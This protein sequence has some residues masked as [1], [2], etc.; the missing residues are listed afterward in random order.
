[1]SEDLPPPPPPPEPIAAPVTPSSSPP[2][3]Q[4]GGDSPAYGSGSV[5]ATDDKLYCTLA[6][7]FSIIIWLWKKD[8]SPAVNVHGRVA[9][10]FHLTVFA[11]CLALYVIA[12]IPLVGCLTV[13]A[14]PIVGLGGLIFSIIGALKANDGTL[15]KYPLSLNLIK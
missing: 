13:F 8:E 10:N 1:M 11:A 15:Y 4:L 12:H 3:G 14:Y 2:T 7:F 6:H 5:S 9:L